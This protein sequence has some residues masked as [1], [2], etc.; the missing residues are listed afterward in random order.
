M[1]CSKLL[2]DAQDQEILHLQIQFAQA[3]DDS[4]NVAIRDRLDEI[5]QEAGIFMEWRLM[6]HEVGILDINRD[7]EGITSV[8]VIIRGRRIWSS[9][10][11]LRA[12]GK[13]WAFED[14]PTKRHIANNT[15]SITQL[16]PKRYAK[17]EKNRRKPKNLFFFLPRIASSAIY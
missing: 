16:D 6:P 9:G 8:G 17:L 7:G 1:S 3:N 5:F 4:K 10:F 15:I 14:H 13:L 11:S 2:S 12:V